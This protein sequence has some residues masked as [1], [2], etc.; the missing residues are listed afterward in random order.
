VPT[1]LPLSRSAV[2]TVMPSLVDL[3]ERV[4]RAVTTGKREPAVAGLVGGADPGKR[5]DI[6]VRHY[7]ASLTAALRDKFAACAWLVGAD[8]VTGA[9]RAYAHAEPPRQLCIADYGEGFPKFLATWGRAPTP[10]YL[11]SFAELE[12]L[13][14]HASI[15]IDQPP[16]AWPT[17]AELGPERLVDAVLTLQPGAGY[18]RATHA[19]DRLMTLYLSGTEPERF[20]LPEAD[21][22]IEVRGARGAVQISPLDTATFAFRSALATGSSIGDAAGHALDCDTAFDPGEALRLLVQN[23]LAIAPSTTT[24]DSSS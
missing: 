9:A 10:R 17:L 12:W 11:E 5:L 24:E 19:V 21:T 4:A 22:F 16:L 1:P 18:L 15:A 23:G 2:A 8:L 3:Q 7:A 6:H 14:G 20:A 13:V